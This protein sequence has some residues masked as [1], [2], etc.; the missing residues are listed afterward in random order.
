MLRCPVEFMAGPHHRRAG[1]MD[2]GDV[3]AHHLVT[4]KNLHI[5]RV[6]IARLGDGPVQ[7][8]VVLHTN[9]L[10]AA[11]PLGAEGE[12][13]GDLPQCLVQ[14][15]GSIHHPLDIAHALEVV[16]PPFH[17]IGLGLDQLGGFVQDLLLRL[18]NNG[19]DDLRSACTD[20]HPAQQ[21]GLCLHQFSPAPSSESASPAGGRSFGSTGA[22]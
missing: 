9:L 22:L 15:S 4:G 3:L 2:G 17:H 19:D 13:D 20:L 12:E 14:L 10:F 16:H 5:H 8:G 6:H 7:S 18:P 1:I 11:L 21:Y